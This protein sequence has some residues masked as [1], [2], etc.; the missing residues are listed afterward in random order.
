MKLIGG[1]TRIWTYRAQGIA[2]NGLP[3]DPAFLE[4][5]IRSAV[6]W[7]DTLLSWIRG[8]EVTVEEVTDEQAEALMAAFRDRLKGH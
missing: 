7:N 4:R 5:V 1:V 2:P 6:S 3:P 8:T